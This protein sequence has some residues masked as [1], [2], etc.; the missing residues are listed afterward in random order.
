MA[1]WDPSSQPQVFSA[2][3]TDRGFSFSGDLDPP[4]FENRNLSREGESR[5]AGLG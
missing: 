5:G 2:S 4:P 1:K 3:T